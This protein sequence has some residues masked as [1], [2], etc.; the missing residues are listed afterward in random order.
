MQ[1]TLSPPSLSDLEARCRE[2]DAACNEL[3]QLIATLNED[4]AAAKAKHLAG[5]KRQAKVVARCESELTQAVEAAPT[6]F[7]KPRTM[8]FHGTKIGFTTAAGAVAFDDEEWVIE[9][10]KR[11]LPKQ[12]EQLVRTKES[13]IKDALKRLPAADLAGIGCRI[14]GAGDLVVVKRADGEVEKLVD[15]MISRLVEAMVNPED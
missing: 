1:A 11:R 4:L 3:E 7:V 14:D 5:I 10:I 15:K 12:V 13:L 8:I 2:Y 6:L 9:A